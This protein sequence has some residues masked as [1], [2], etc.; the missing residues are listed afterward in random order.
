MGDLSKPN[1]E[2]IY[3]TIWKDILCKLIYI[4]EIFAL[5]ITYNLR[6]WEIYM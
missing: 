5:D 1:L 2:I 3:N 4:L 6:Y